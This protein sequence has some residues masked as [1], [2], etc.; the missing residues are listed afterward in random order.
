MKEGKVICFA[1]Q[2]DESQDLARVIVVSLLNKLRSE[3]S[4]FNNVDSMEET[5]WVRAHAR[6]TACFRRGAVHMTRGH[7]CMIAT[8]RVFFL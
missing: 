5:I 4:R 3:R 8:H 2:T 7:W 6:S 1:L